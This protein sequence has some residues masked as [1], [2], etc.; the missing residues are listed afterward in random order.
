MEQFVMKRL[1]VYRGRTSHWFDIL[2]YQT[3]NMD[4]NRC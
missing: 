3:W 4:D 2:G 1:L